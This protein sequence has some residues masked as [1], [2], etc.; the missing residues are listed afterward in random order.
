MLMSLPGVRRLI[1]IFTWKMVSGSLLGQERVLLI[2]LEEQVEFMFRS[3]NLQTF[4]GLL[5]RYLPK[6]S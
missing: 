2:P 1:I 5:N 4:A 6:R 3:L